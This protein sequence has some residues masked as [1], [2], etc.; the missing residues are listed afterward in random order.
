MLY[1]LFWAA[2]RYPRNLLQTTCTHELNQLPLNVPSPQL[3]RVGSSA[4]RGV[5]M[6]LQHTAKLDMEHYLHMNRALVMIATL[7]P[8]G[9]VCLLSSAIHPHWRNVA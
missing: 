3:A 4:I 7:Q 8:V 9:H 6:A 2:T 1:F 5:Y